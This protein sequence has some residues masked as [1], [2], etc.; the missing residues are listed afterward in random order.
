MIRHS[1]LETI[2]TAR[3]NRR[4]LAALGLASLGLAIPALGSGATAQEA[5]RA[6]W[7]SQ[8][9]PL[10]TTTITVGDQPLTVE[11]ALSPAS[12]ARGLGYR[13]GL[14]PGTGML[15][16]FPES[17]GRSFWMKGMRFCLDII[18]IDQ[19]EITGAAQSV[20]PDPPGTAD[21]DRASFRSETAAECVLEVPAGWMEEHGFGPGTPVDIPE[22]VFDE[23]QR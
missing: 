17:A 9:T 12:R 1:P 6:P 5:V 8:T 23:I 22:W 16:V 15:F 10:D 11:L 2:R 19:G 14:A 13:P 7:Q 18:W 3:P 20:C 4:R 21:A